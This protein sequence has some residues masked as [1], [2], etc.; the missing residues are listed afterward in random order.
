MKDTQILDVSKNVK[1]IGVL[2]ADIRTFDIVMEPQYGTTYNSY[3]IN[4]EKKAIVEA[5]K[6]KFFD[7]FLPKLETLCNPSELEYIF[8]NHT[9]P[10]H[11][12]GLK[13]LLSIAPNAKVVASSCAIKFLEAQ[14]GEPFPHII[15]QEGTSIDLGNMHI[16]IIAAPNLHWPDSIYSYLPEEEVI[17]T[18]DSFGAHFCHEKMYNNEVGNY[19]DAF[20]YY[21]DVIL[22]PF[23][24]FFLQAID[25]IRNLP[26][27]AICNGHGP[28]LTHEPMKVVEKTEALCREYLENY[29]KKNRVL[30]AYVSAY[31][32]TKTIAEKLKE[33]LQQ[34]EG[35]EVD[36]CDIEKMDA[37]ELG[38]KIAMASAYLLGSPTINR[39]MLPQMYTTLALMTSLR[40]KGKLAAAFGSYGWTGEA[41]KML[42]VNFEQMRLKDFG[43][44][45]FVKF[46]PQ[47][48]D[49]EKIVDF[50]KRFGM[51]VKK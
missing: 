40:D 12:G 17:F 18:C 9:E 27:K 31:G 49:F 47:E 10:D 14:I 38:D 11:A 26:I 15:A 39:N 37:G 33:G 25:K 48:R 35:I 23:S 43:E 29:P 44:S 41:E 50:G 19:D 21:F 51:Q 34:V 3:F 20:Q 2:D 28:L 6:E 24:A 1:W 8:V 46:K 13:R 45:M 5:V 7:V 4:A 22:K 42:K 16:E 32:F 36:C 30:L